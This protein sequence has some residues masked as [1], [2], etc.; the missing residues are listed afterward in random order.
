MPALEP[1]CKDLGINTN[2]FLKEELLLL[3]AELFHHL[4]EGLKSIFKK[5]YKEYFR[6]SKFNSDL[7]ELMIDGNF[8]SCIIRDLIHTETYTL[9]GIALYTQTSEGIISRIM[10]GHNKNPSLV[11]ARKIIELHRT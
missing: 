5:Q 8:L 6:I 11:L 7:E 1:L 9:S 2:K 3:E 10:S 4:C